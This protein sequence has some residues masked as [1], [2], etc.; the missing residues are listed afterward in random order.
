[1]V[2]Q[3]NWTA[4]E[5]IIMDI[6]IQTHGTKWLVIKKY[7]PNRSTSMIRNRYLRRNSKKEGIN[8]CVI[9]GKVRLGHTCYLK[10]LQC[11]PIDPNI[12]TFINPEDKMEDAA[13]LLSIQ[14]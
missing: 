10:Q 11:I 9:C 1:M 4:E 7:F 8:K 12:R 13:L 3:K 2:N 14:K 6:L 5:D